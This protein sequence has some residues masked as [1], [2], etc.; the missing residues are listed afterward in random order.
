MF[1]FAG[2][3]SFALFAF[4]AWA[5]IDVLVTDKERIRWGWKPVWI[6]LVA[7]GGPAGAFGWLFFGRPKNAGLIPGG[8][9][10]FAAERQPTQPQAKF[11]D[12]LNDEQSAPAAAPVIPSAPL[13]P[14]DS[15]EWAAWVAT[16]APPPPGV[17]ATDPLAS[18]DFADWEAE[19]DEGDSEG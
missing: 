3:I 10:K 19:L 9:K 1:Q 16:N 17:V 6:G 14:E 2:I 12:E 4:T 11:N 8:N 15:P 7:I 13:G 5:I 18:M